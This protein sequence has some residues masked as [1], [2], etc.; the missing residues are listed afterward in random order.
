MGYRLQCI[1]HNPTYVAILNLQPQGVDS[2]TPLWLKSQLLQE[3]GKRKQCRSCDLTVIQQVP[4][5]PK[6]YTYRRESPIHRTYTFRNREF[7]V[8]DMLKIFLREYVEELFNGYEKYLN[9]EEIK[10]H[11]QKV[12]NT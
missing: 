7:K 11:L 6:R 9:I 10:E 3:S 8:N 1:I 5:Q 4:E 12:V 2:T